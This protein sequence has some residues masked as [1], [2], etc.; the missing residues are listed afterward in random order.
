MVC[1][2]QMPLL[3]LL[4]SPIKSQLKIRTLTDWAVRATVF[5]YVLWLE[6]IHSHIVE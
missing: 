5:S 4:F 2:S 1:S 6:G 3:L